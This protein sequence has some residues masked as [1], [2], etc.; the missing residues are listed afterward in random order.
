MPEP[1]RNSEVY[2]QAVAAFHRAWDATVEVM[3]RQKAGLEPPASL[4]TT[5]AMPWPLP[6][7]GAE[8]YTVAV[9]IFVGPVKELAEVQDAQT[10]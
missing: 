6:E 2:Q 4:M 5:M 7:F 8:P 3:R 10:S 9:T 1:D